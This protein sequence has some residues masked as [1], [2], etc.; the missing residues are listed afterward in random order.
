MAGPR[1]PP[2]SIAWGHLAISSTL[3]SPARRFLGRLPVTL[4]LL[5]LTEVLPGLGE[6]ASTLPGA[7]GM[8]G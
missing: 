6:P 2:T 1:R 7:Q 3:P 8:Q 5:P 4:C